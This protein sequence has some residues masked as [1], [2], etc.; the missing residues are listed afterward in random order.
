MANLQGRPARSLQGMYRSLQ[1]WGGGKNIFITV[2]KAFYGKLFKSGIGASSFSDFTTHL[3]YGSGDGEFDGISGIDVKENL[4]FIADHNNHRIQAF[5]RDVL[6]QFDFGSVGTGDGQFQ[7]PSG[8]SIYGGQ[9]YV[10]DSANARVQVFG[11]DGVFDR[12][13]G[14]YGTGTGELVNVQDV[15]VYNDVVYVAESYPG[16]S[17]VNLFDLDGTYISQFGSEGT[18]DGQFTDI[19]ANCI[20]NIGDTIY[21]ANR[22]STA[23]ESHI[24]LFDLSGNFIS[25]YEENGTGDGE[26]INPRSISGFGGKLYVFDLS[27]DRII[28]FDSDMNFIRNIDLSSLLVSGLLASQIVVG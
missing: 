1:G 21:V 12:K 11:I 26:F 28:V 15:H 5:D 2:S 17:G 4:V 7:F 6:F 19:Q 18:G 13:F 14:T 8:V 20:T 3:D 10:G 23:G 16:F 9:V 25:K 22:R 27:N 24:Q